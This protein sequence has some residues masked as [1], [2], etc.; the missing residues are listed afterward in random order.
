M[1]GTIELNQLTEADYTMSI[2][3]GD[4]YDASA[5]WQLCP[6]D[7]IEMHAV[8]WLKTYKRL[9]RQGLGIAQL[10]MILESWCNM[11]QMSAA[12]LRLADLQPCD[13]WFKAACRLAQTASI[14]QIENAL[15]IIRDRGEFITAV[16]A[17]AHYELFS[18]FEL[19]RYVVRV[20]IVNQDGKTYRRYLNP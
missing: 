3:L 8:D 19:G 12:A 2:A 14:D 6:D 15:F 18:S 4:N 20:E 13:Q 17:L 7:L 9:T 10:E 16:L 5:E 1:K 11:T